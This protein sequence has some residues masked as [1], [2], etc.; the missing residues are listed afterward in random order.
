MAE[1]TE[2]VIED[3]FTEDAA[4]GEEHVGESIAPAGDD[5]KSEI[6]A[7]KLPVDPSLKT[8]KSPEE[9]AAIMRESGQLN[10]TDRAGAKPKGK[11][12]SAGAVATSS[13]G[14]PS[15][16]SVLDSIPGLTE[17]PAEGTAYAKR[18]AE[19]DAA[20]ASGTKVKLTPAQ[21]AK[22][23]AA[24]AK[25]KAKEAADKA[26]EKAKLATEKA[27]EKDKE[28]KTKA[29]EQSENRKK[30]EAERKA[31]L[32]AKKEA[33]AKAKAASKVPDLMSR[34]NKTV[35]AA[36]AEDYAI[37]GPKTERNPGGLG[38][39]RAKSDRGD[40]AAGYVMALRR[41]RKAQGGATQVVERAG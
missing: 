26:R 5:I 2:Q 28:K 18:K 25:A 36:F 27:K 19:I 30:L 39:R 1:S 31:N 38:I 6:Q 3:L 41:L 33:D 40:F 17:T 12:R 7:G 13:A 37:A 10:S 14:E 15:E 21:K 34:E 29:Q 23:V 32:A 24:R 22:E 16:G 8:V 11:A 9:Q 20:K 4:E 35:Q